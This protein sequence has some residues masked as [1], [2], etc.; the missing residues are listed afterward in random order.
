MTK[1]E[2]LEQIKKT[3]KDGYEKSLKEKEKIGQV[4]KYDLNEAIIKT[5]CYLKAEDID[6]DNELIELIRT[7]LEPLNTVDNAMKFF[8]EEMYEHVKIYCDKYPS[9]I[10]YFDSELQYSIESVA[11]FWKKN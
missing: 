7:G 1:E 4:E 6:I 9:D 5:A 8:D 10:G 3:I 11:N 2:F